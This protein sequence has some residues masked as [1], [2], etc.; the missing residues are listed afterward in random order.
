MCTGLKQIDHPYST[1]F[2]SLITSFASGAKYNVMNKA[3]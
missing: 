2:T 1:L 3:D